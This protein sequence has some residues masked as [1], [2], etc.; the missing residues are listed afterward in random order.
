MAITYTIDEEACSTTLL[1]VAMTDEVRAEPLVHHLLELA[2]GQ[3][4]GRPQLID[5]RGG[6]LRL[7]R[8]DV[9][10]LAQLVAGLRRIHGVSR[11]GMV[12]TD[13][14]TFGVARMYAILNEQADPGFA[15][16]RDLAEAEAWVCGNG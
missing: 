3:L 12:T 9:Q 14:A 8:A 7:S 6:R 5:L 10:W 16:F 13:D 4:F 11:V 15:V 1:R 2:A